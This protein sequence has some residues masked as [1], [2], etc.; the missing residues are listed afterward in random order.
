MAKKKE[1][2]KLDI[3]E[4]NKK[5]GEYTFQRAER[6]E[7][8]TIRTPRYLTGIVLFDMLLNG[9][10]PQ[11]KIVAIGSEPGIGKTTLLVNA[12]GNIAT[13]KPD[14]RI[15]YIDVEGGAS[16]EL[17]DD[18]GFSHL[19][20]DPEG[21]PSGNIYLMNRAKSIQSI[22]KICKVVL[23]DPD[24]A[25]VI[26]DSDTAVTDDNLL[27]EEDLGTSKNAVGANARL[28]SAA[29][30]PINALVTNSNA[31]MIIVHQARVDISGW[32]PVV[33]SAGGNAIKHVASVEIW[34]KRKGW[35]AADNTITKKKEEA[36]G[37][38]MQLQTKK[39]RLTVPFA[40]VTVPVIFGRG[41]SNKLAYKLWLENHGIED[42]VTGEVTPYINWGKSGYG[43]F[44][45]SST[46]TPIKFR[47]EAECWNLVE[48]YYD[49]VVALV[50]SSGGFTLERADD[51]DEATE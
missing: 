48:K 5:L 44:R 39:N 4:L 45:L 27:L 49:Q 51:D 14:K 1:L 42:S 3:K 13:S 16:Y 46:F 21:N 30:R 47:G 35:I 32:M 34:G 29:I 15:Y 19:L 40:A 37:A 9:G 22:A 43:D 24:T 2:E 7:D 10:L 31:C 12:C 33:E 20:Y 25:L 11:G 50:D 26:I 8:G 18:M 38:L 23:S 36:V 17:W 6:N 41:I 28:W